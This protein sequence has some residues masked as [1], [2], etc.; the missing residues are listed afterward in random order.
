MT[1]VTT[2]E[3][4]RGGVD[5]SEHD[6]VV[7]VNVTP[8]ELEG[9]VLYIEYIDKHGKVHRVEATNCKII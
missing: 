3:A 2:H 9:E 1:V 8:D 6:R 4:L 5:F 7:A